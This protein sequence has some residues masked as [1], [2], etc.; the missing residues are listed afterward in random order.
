[1][2][3]V[4]VSSR[5]QEEAG[6]KPWKF[7]DAEGNT[8][9]DTYICSKS[10]TR[11]IVGTGMREMVIWMSV[12]LLVDSLQHLSTNDDFPHVLQSFHISVRIFTL[13]GVTIYQAIPI[14]QLQ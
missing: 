6:N 5:D 4:S 1:M 8:L 11:A 2:E 10:T 7:E 13:L 3:S 12:L 14:T 9:S